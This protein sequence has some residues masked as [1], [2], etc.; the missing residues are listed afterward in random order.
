M[1]TNIVNIFQGPV[2][3]WRNEALP[4]DCPQL[5]YDAERGHS[6][7]Q[8]TQSIQPIC[9]IKLAPLEVFI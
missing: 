4:V 1:A 7:L 2:P 5:S 8:G 3:K 9:L 6:S